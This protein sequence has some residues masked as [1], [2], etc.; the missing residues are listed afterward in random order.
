MNSGALVVNSARA[1]C[2]P[3]TH[4]STPGV[5]REGSGSVPK[6]RAML[7]SLFVILVVPA[8][9]VSCGGGGGGSDAPPPFSAGQATLTSANAPGYATAVDVAARMAATMRIGPSLNQV[10]P[11]TLTDPGCGVGG[12]GPANL[13]VT[14]ST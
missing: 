7:R 9:L 10:T 6:W 12:A 4:N 5:F 11:G 14:P 2:L 13:T 8:A 1:L 3:T